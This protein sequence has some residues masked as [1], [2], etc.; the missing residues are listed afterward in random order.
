[1]RNNR[2]GVTLKKKKGPHSS[3]SYDITSFC[4]AIPLKDNIIVAET[5]RGKKKNQKINCLYRHG[6]SY[7][8]CE[9]VPGSS[10][11]GSREFE[12]WTESVRKTYLLI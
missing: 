8:P 1:M 9:K 11:G 2:K 10:P 3:C 12:E 5:L 6:T 4:L 7:I